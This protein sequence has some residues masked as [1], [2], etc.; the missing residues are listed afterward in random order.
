MLTL[1]SALQYFYS[2]CLEY[3]DISLIES[4]E[5]SSGYFGGQ[6]VKKPNVMLA[7]N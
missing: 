2:K 5:I 7:C 6:I 1:I 4:G 3:Y